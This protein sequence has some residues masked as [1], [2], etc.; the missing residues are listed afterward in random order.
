MET[1][2]RILLNTPS[3]LKIYLFFYENYLFAQYRTAPTYTCMSVFMQQSNKYK[4][5][6]TVFSYFG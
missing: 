2:L 3:Q 4:D 6:D 1:M 5:E